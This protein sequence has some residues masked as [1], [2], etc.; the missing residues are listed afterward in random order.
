MAKL[1]KRSRLAQHRHS[2]NQLPSNPKKEAGQ[3][4]KTLA[5]IDKLKSSNSSINEKLITIN[6]ILVQCN[7]DDLARKIFLKN[8][9]IKVLLKD[10]FVEDQ[11]D[12]LLVSALDLINHLIMHEESDL[13]IYLWRNGIWEILEA[14]F[15]KSFKS[16]DH[17]NDSNVNQISK[18]L[19]ISYVNNLVAIIDNL[20]MQLNSNLI[21]S[22]IIPKLVS[23]GIL[24]KLFGIV[25]IPSIALNILQFFYDLST[26]STD[27]LKNH[28]VNNASL[29]INTTDPL[30]QIYLL[31]IN[32]QILEIN[33]DLMKN[34]N[35]L[36][37]KIFEILSTLKFDSSEHE[38]K[39]IDTSLDLLTTLIEIKG[40]LENPDNEFNEQCIQLILPFVGKLFQIDDPNTKKLICLNNLLIYLISHNLVSDQLVAD[41]ESLSPKIAI[42]NDI[43]SIIDFLNF[44]LNLLEIDNTKFM[45]ELNT[46]NE[47]IELGMKKVNYKD[48]DFTNIELQIQFITSLLLYLSL[49][50]KNINN[51][52]VTKKIVEFIVQN[53][54]IIPIEFYNKQIASTNVSKFHSKYNY[55]V[56]ES[57]NLSVNSI[58]ELFDDD[59]SYNKEI[60]HNGNLN[61]VL[62]NI[63]A[64]YK[65]IYKNIDKN[66]NFQLKKQTEES[67]NN[68]Q[69]FIEYKN[70]ELK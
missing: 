14:N 28:L 48:L 16:L 42:S 56:E 31:G 46:I 20:I 52:E 25:S 44:K 32:L 29:N 12:E 22:Q 57:I 7:N 18:D 4:S 43:E 30:S 67:I 66:L 51:I 5:L 64:D 35:S 37:T 40:S 15:T 59:Y 58:F 10:I 23:S 69:R 34:L 62:K 45:L 6:N 17:L 19:L 33:N 61:D 53:N 26:I 60:Y 8:D 2:N 27:F 1:K 36:I 21:N 9:L 50:A 39:I 49:I 41:L 70:S 65:K 38:F 47:L 54:L 13:S 11:F 68:L 55:L 24:E 63:L 3:T